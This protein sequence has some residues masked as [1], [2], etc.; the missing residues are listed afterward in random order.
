MKPVQAG[1]GQAGSSEDSARDYAALLGRVQA[2]LQGT[3]PVAADSL[4]RMLS[5]VK[6]SL[7][8]GARERLALAQVADMF[9][10]CLN[11]CEYKSADAQPAPDISIESFIFCEAMAA[12][13]G[14][15]FSTSIVLQSS[16][17]LQDFAYSATSLE[18]Y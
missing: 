11:F 3:D 7:D 5:L 15:V 17:C 10:V 18:C 8:Q 13:W 2:S 4:C 12:C 14:V 16:I 1:N 6:E 9:R